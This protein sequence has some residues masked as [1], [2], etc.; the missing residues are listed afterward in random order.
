MIATQ[1]KLEE[2]MKKA[3][4]W[5]LGAAVLTTLAAL[6]GYG[7]TAQDV[8]NKMIDAIGGRKTLE[9]IKDT[10]ITGTVEITSPMPITAPITIYQKEPDKVRMDI[11]I[12]ELGI[13][14]TQ[15]YD[16]QKAWSTNPQTGAAEQ[17]PD[18]MTKEFSRQALGNQAFL[19][20]QKLGITYALKPKAAIEG[21]D[22]IVLEQTL[23]DG[24]KNTF[25]LDPNT[26]LP[27]KQQGKSIDQTGGE[28]DQE[29]FLSN[30]QKVGGTMV[31]FSMRV[32]Q[33][34]TEA[35]K[36]TLAGVTYNTK[37]DDALFLMK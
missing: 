26:Y 4:A 34:G 9:A 10:T 13:T 30:Y 20:P 7:Q 27:F 6:P 1:K 33:N 18:F 16:G 29:T 3:T 35:Q 5:I 12:S 22:Y 2:L 24:Y 11:D 19:N 14:I 36:V 32:L 21:K 17:L 28:V 23:S 31:A 25:F 15:A 37:L 8:L